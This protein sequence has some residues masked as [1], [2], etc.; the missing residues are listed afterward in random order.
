MAN[1][2]AE[3]ILSQVDDS[4]FHSYILEGILDAKKNK[5]A[6]GPESAFIVTQ[7]G[8]R[9]LRQMTMGWNLKVAWKDGTSQ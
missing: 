8:Q 4:G 9:K 3:N 2:I 6:L 5:R 1:I 7:S